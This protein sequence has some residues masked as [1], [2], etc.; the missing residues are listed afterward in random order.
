MNNAKG[1][2]HS[3]KSKSLP[4]EHHL[5]IKLHNQFPCILEILCLYVCVTC[6]LFYIQ[7]IAHCAVM[8]LILSP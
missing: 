3:M 7:A 8:H 1:V 6:F 5:E 4:S 2:E